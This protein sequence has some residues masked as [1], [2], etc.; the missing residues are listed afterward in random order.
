MLHIDNSDVLLAIRYLKMV[1]GE[2]SKCQVITGA[3]MMVD[4][5]GGLLGLNVPLKEYCALMCLPLPEDVK[6]IQNA[7]TM[8]E[9]GVDFIALAANACNAIWSKKREHEV[10]AYSGD[11]HDEMPLGKRQIVSDGRSE[12]DPVNVASPGAGSLGK[13]VLYM[14]QKYNCV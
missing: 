10:V 12:L 3:L 1:N 7:R 13:L 4:K 5:D 14:Q 6:E 9:E 11:D 2:E 8:I